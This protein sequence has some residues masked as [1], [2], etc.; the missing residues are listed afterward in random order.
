[1]SSSRADRAVRIA[2]VILSIIYGFGTLGA[3][4]GLVLTWTRGEFMSNDELAIRR[5]NFVGG[6]VAHGT[7]LFGSVMAIR[8]YRMNTPLSTAVLVLI[9]IWLCI[10]PLSAIAALHAK[11][12]AL[13]FLEPIV[14]LPLL[15]VF[16]Y[17]IWGR[18]VSRNR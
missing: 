1:M 14:V 11:S 16:G 5:K 17:G 8:L 12:S 6:V 9:A 15:V 7:R 2:L 18:L 4:L 10:G 13:D 3:L